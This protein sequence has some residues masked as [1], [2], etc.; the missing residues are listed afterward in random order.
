MKAP[1]RWVPTLPQITAETIAVI[2]GAV[3]GAII[4]SQFPKLKKWLQD[5]YSAPPGA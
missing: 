4:I 2:A 5:N 1:T 3:L